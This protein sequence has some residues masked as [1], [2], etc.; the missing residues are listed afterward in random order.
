MMNG[1]FDDGDDDGGDG[2]SGQ[3]THHHLTSPGLNPFILNVLI[4]EMFLL[5]FNEN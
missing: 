4:I 3:S 2:G 1:K 5:N